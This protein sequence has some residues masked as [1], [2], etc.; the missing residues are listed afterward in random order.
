MNET[1]KG[2]ASLLEEEG[3]HPCKNGTLGKVSFEEAGDKF[4]KFAKTLELLLLNLPH[5]KI[6]VTFNAG[7]R[8]GLGTYWAEVRR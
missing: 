5:I 4:A 2:V 7:A 8:N 6:K 3:Y 1:L